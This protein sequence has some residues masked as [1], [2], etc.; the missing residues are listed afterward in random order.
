MRCTAVVLAGSR[1]G[2]DPFARAYGTDLKALIPVGGRPMVARPVD[3]LLQ[4]KEIGS[5]LVLAQEPER[6]ADVLPRDVRITVQRSGTTIAGTLEALCFDNS[7]EWPLLVT[8]AD[9]ALLSSDMIEDF[10]SLARDA[11]IGI[12][13]VERRA[14]MYRLPQ[15]DRTWLPFRGGAYSGANLFLLGSRKVVS[16]L[17]LWRA[18]EQDRKRAWRLMWMLGPTAFLGAALRLRTLDQTVS[19]IGR[20]LG[21]NIRAAELADPL[22]AVDVDKPV[23]H[24]LV[25]AILEGRA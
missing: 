24:S 9:H 16:A 7:V 12:G 10:L 5:I 4:S 19:T 18:V 2:G 13:V 8:T 23:D 6:I 11:D 20:R 22:A 1:P 3:A 14:L 17:E 25:E 21:L 15:S